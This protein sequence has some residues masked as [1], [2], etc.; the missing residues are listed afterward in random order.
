MG[1][2]PATPLPDHTEASDAG[3]WLT[4]QER[5]DRHDALVCFDVSPSAV[6]FVPMQV[7]DGTDTVSWTMPVLP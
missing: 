2:R 6:G 4:F 1:Y 7:T 5:P 3:A